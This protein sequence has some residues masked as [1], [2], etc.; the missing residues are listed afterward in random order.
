MTRQLRTPT[1]VA[2]VE[3]P[4]RVHT[5]GTVLST[6]CFEHLDLLKATVRFISD[7]HAASWDR[8]STPTHPPSPSPLTLHLQRQ[9]EPAPKTLLLVGRDTP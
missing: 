9:P 2:V 4:A 6:L 8:R 7:T 3:M 1:T 5:L